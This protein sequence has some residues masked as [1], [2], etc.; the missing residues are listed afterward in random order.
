MEKVCRFDRGYV[1][2]KAERTSEG[3]IVAD[4][5]VTRTGVFLYQ[6]G[7]GTMRRELRHPDDVFS[8]ASMDSLKMIPITNNHPEQKMVSAENAK[9][10]SIGQTGE[11]VYTDGAHLHASLK[12]TTKDGVE[13][14][15]QGRKELS[16][17]YSLDLEKTEGVYN[18]ERYDYRQ[19]NI[20]YN[21]LAI[22]ERA[23]AGGAARLNLDASDAI[24]V[25]AKDQ[26]EPKKEQTKMRK[27]NI[28]G[29]EY[30][31]APEVANA[32]TKANDRADAAESL[33][34]ATQANLDAE[35]K[36]K[37]KIEAE[38]DELKEKL[39]SRD[40]AAT[41]H[42]QVQAR[43]ELERVAGKVL[44]KD[45]KISEMT[46]MEIKHAVIKA[47]STNADL[48]LDEKSNDYIDARFD[49]AVEA[50]NSEKSIADQKQQ[51]GE[52]NDGSGKKETLDEKRESA[53]DAMKNQHKKGDK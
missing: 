21:H 1:S 42:K 49:S 22:V 44:N 24:Q 27:V 47:K 32:L 38:R 5:V 37:A 36:E 2:G 31:A 4:A 13:S 7:D 39:E 25:D 30:D 52:R 41:V 46:D 53:F 51:M 29:I 10:L 16:C 9:E 14:V 23:R 26:N 18:G 17:G 35:A 43:L 6:N 20:R 8:K 40:D 28:D 19:R 50:I 45:A 33:V 34:K 15:E 12:I 3:Y 11:N 48:N